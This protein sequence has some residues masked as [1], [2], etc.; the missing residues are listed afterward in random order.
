MID[1]SDPLWIATL[2]MCDG[3]RE[4]ALQMLEDPDS[5]ACHPGIREIMERESSEQ[6]RDKVTGST[7]VDDWDVADESRKPPGAVNSPLLSASL[8]SPVANDED[9]GFAEDDAVLEESDPRS[10]LNLVFIG[11]VDAGKVSV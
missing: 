3:D 9:G 5:L 1:E 2:A 6:I 11:H 4:K 8:P 10:H 7:G